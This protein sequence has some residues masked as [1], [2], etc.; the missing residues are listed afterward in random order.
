[1]CEAVGSIIGPCVSRHFNNKKPGCLDATIK[2]GIPVTIF[3]FWV[4]NGKYQAIILEGNWTSNCIFVIF[5]FFKLHITF[6]SVQLIGNTV[7]PK[8]HLLGNNGLV[9]LPKNFNMTTNFPKWI[10]QGF[11]H[12]ICVVS[13]HHGQAL[14]SLAQHCQVNILESVSYH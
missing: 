14:T 9:E 2:I 10:Q 8:R 13:G 6:L 4:M 1:M 7:K 12:H 3:R 5:F 11:P